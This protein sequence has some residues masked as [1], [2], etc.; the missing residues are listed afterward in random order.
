MK[1]NNIN[2]E[3]HLSYNTNKIISELIQEI[4]LYG[5]Y[6]SDYLT[7]DH[8]NSYYNR[9]NQLYILTTGI[10]TIRTR[11]KV[12]KVK[13]LILENLKLFVK[14]QNLRTH[15][16]LLIFLNMIKKFHFLI[17][18]GLQEK[19]FFFR[20]MKNKKEDIEEVI[21]SH[22]SRDTNILIAIQV[23]TIIGIATKTFDN[24]CFNN[25]YKYFNR[26][27]QFFI[28]VRNIIEEETEKLDYLRKK[29]I[30][31]LIA[32]EKNKKLR[33]NENLIIF[34]E[35]IKEIYNLLIL[36][37]QDKKFFFRTSIR[38]DKSLKKRISNFNTKD[39]YG[40]D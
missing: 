39:I 38:R 34:L 6:A 14:N 4:I 15:L 3:S 20:I 12:I 7:L 23:M 17:I 32:F 2:L 25:L 22:N 8:I 28:F 13:E 36:G 26:I 33:T 31:D 30:D 37:L 21:D 24:I 10:H 18:T 1:Y 5:Y 9:V 35:E 27:D 19:Q 29:V 11:T 16:N 40:D